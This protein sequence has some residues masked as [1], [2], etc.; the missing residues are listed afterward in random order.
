MKV[1]IID[2]YRATTVSTAF[3]LASLATAISAVAAIE[4]RVQ[5]LN[6]RSY[7]YNLMNEFTPGHRIP[8]LATIIPVFLMALLTHIT[9]LN[10][11]HIFFGYGAAYVIDDKY[12]HKLPKY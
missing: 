1:P 11:L 6:E 5:L 9:A 2:G 7:I 3:L 8:W 4:T 10:L 12:K